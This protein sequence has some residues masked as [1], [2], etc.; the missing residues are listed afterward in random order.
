MILLEA[1]YSSVRSVL[2]W[3]IVGDISQRS[4]AVYRAHVKLLLDRRR[5]E[6]YNQKYICTN[7]LN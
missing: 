1:K 2:G 6:I 7:K 3:V 4:A 5:I